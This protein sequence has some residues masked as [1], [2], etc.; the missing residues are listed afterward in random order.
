MDEVGY[1]LFL[2]VKHEVFEPISMPS[3]IVEIWC[4]SPRIFCPSDCGAH[5]ECLVATSRLLGQVPV[6]I[7]APNRGQYRR[8]RCPVVPGIFYRLFYPRATHWFATDVP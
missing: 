7:D 8:P 3:Q 6:A 1:G 2:G 4:L 5:A